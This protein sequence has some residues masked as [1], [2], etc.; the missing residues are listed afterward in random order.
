ML[1]TGLRDMG[2]KVF[3]QDAG[4]PLLSDCFE[5]ILTEWYSPVS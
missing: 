2:V 5:D 4:A 1:L 3:G